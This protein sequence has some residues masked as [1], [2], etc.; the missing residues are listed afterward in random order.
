MILVRLVDGGVQPHI[1]SKCIALK[2]PKQG[3]K[4]TESGVG[5]AKWIK[6]GTSET[7]KCLHCRVVFVLIR[8][9]SGLDVCNLHKG[10][11]QLLNF[12]ID[13]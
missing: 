12:L 4:G 2:L 8:F 13:C 1:S 5:F 11:F 6:F 7:K 9:H 3:T 10:H